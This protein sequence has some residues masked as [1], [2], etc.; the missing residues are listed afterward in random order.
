[1]TEGRTRE[2]RVN[3]MAAALLAEKLAA[4]HNCDCASILLTAALLEADA[5]EPPPP[6]R[7]PVAMCGPRIVV[8]GVF[9]GPRPEDL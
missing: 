5:T 1:M 2:A 7:N 9:A 6:R 4:A 8:N 3:F